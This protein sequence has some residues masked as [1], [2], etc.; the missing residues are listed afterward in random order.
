MEETVLFMNVLNCSESTK[1]PVFHFD[2]KS[3]FVVL[4]NKRLIV[5]KKLPK[6]TYPGKYTASDFDDASLGPENISI[7]L[8][9]ITEAKAGRTKGLTPYL[10]ISY[11]GPTGQKF[12]TFWSDNELDWLS[13]MDKWV[14]AINSAK[15]NTGGGKI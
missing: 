14:K 15:E 10:T 3:P 6:Q 1:V 9:Q 4:T 2:L 7:P 13:N 12:Y 11:Q 5:L 8:T